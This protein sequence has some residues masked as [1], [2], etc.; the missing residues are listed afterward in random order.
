MWPVLRVCLYI[1]LCR[2]DKPHATCAC[3]SGTTYSHVPVA[4]YAKHAIIA[5]HPLSLCVYSEIIKKQ[6]AR[7]YRLK[8][9]LRLTIPPSVVLLVATVRGTITSE[10]ESTGALTA[11]VALASPWV[12]SLF[13]MLL[14]HNAG[15]QGGEFSI[16]VYYIRYFVWRRS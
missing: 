10:A 5:P 4:Y 8:W 13:S 9:G 1:C 2:P 14:F 3:A 11:M 7:T 6:V 15:A 12:V 16:T